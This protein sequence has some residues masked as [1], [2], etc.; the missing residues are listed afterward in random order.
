MNER[1]QEVVEAVRLETFETLME[2]VRVQLGN[3]QIMDAGL[4][5]WHCC[6]LASR[7]AMDVLRDHFI[8]ARAVK[9]Q[10]LTMNRVAWEAE[11]RG[12]NGAKVPGGVS[13]AC[14]L[15]GDGS[16][17]H[18]QEGWLNGHVVLLVEGEV[19]LDASAVQ[20]TRV[21]YG[22]LVEPL[23]I[24]LTDEVGDQFLNEDA[25]VVAPLDDD[26]GAILYHKHPDKSGVFDSN[27]WISR[28][29]HYAVLRDAV[30]RAVRQRLA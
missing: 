14:G 11:K 18:V 17:D 30:G 9:V 23:V 26:M 5:D 6:V 4:S 20:F 19:L 10:T 28:E 25:W 15:I 1:E 7:V 22:V 3:G 27:D 13:W 12:E 16:Q 2:G 8:G 24:G 29:L 21:E